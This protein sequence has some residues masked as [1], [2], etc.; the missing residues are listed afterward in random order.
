[1][2]V[3]SNLVPGPRHCRALLPSLIPQL[4]EEADEDPGDEGGGPTAPS[5]TYRED[6]A[7]ADLSDTGLLSAN[8]FF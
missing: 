1:M 7:K 2:Q 8:Q 5:Q 6:G 4:P 3:L